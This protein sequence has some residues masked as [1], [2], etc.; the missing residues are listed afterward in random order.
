[1]AHPAAAVA[2]GKARGGQTATELSLRRFPGG[3]P[4]RLA[5]ER[6]AV[7]LL[8]VWATW[9]EP[10]REALPA[11]AALRDRYAARG[12]KVYA[13]SVDAEPSQIAAFLLEAKAPLPV[14]L[15]PEGAA[16]EAVLGVKLMPTSFLVDRAGVIRHVHE[17]FDPEV[18]ARLPAEL[19]ALLGEGPPR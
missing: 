11:Y 13:V 9:C 1:V 2:E 8:D 6:G 17:G 19:D 12:L 7:V 15:D 14:L 10:C 5:D 3:E 18:L 16:A 4:W